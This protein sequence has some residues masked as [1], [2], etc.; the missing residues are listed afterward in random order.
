MVTQSGI[1]ATFTRY[2]SVIR[3]GLWLRAVAKNCGSLRRFTASYV[4]RCRQILPPVFSDYFSD[5]LA[6]KLHGYILVFFLSIHY[7]TRKDFIVFTVH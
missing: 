4:N 7:I 1:R 2:S 6:F 5:Y 3:T